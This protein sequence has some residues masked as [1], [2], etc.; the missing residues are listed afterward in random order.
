[1]DEK[2]LTEL[3]TLIYKHA[4][5]WLETPDEEEKEDTPYEVIMDGLEIPDTIP[6]EFTSEDINGNPISYS[7]DEVF[8][9]CLYGCTYQEEDGLSVKLI[10][11]MIKQGI[12]HIHED[13]DTCLLFSDEDTDE[14]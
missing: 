12:E 10:A 7:L 8:N 13:P 11:G 5:K 14:E 4:Q 9:A 3:A 6:S 2:T 1:M